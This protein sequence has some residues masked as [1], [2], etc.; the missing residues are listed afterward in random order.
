[1]SISPKLKEEE[2]FKPPLSAKVSRSTKL[3]TAEFFARPTHYLFWGTLTG[4]IIG[5]FCGLSFS[6]PLYTIVG[7]LGINQFYDVYKKRP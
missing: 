2:A 7:L 6:W 3:F 1:M 4:I 5:L